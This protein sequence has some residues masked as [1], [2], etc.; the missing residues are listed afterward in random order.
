MFPLTDS[1]TTWE[2]SSPDFRFAAAVAGYGML[3]RD[4]SNRGQATWQS[5]TEWAREGLGSDV[6]GRRAEFLG[7][8]EKAKAVSP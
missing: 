2:K 4:S 1:A 7:L 3:L 5:V 6:G 8:I